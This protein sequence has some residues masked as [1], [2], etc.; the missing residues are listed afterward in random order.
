MHENIVVL[1]LGCLSGR[2]WG[3]CRVF[4]HAVPTEE[5]RV[6]SDEAGA[7]AL[8]ELT[9][10]AVGRQRHVRA[11]PAIGSDGTVYVTTKSYYDPATG[12]QPA[13]ASPSCPTAR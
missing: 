1:R 3:S 11:S 12:A 9:A 10:L 7:F 8:G 6:V 2:L 5:L 13:C 4:P